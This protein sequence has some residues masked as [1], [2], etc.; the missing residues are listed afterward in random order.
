MNILCEK[1]MLAFFSLCLVKI[2]FCQDIP[3]INK[4]L[5]SKFSINSEFDYSKGYYLKNA[6]IVDSFIFNK[7][8]LDSV[9]SLVSSKNIE[10][11]SI[12]NSFIK[13]HHIYDLTRDVYVISYENKKELIIPKKEH[14]AYTGYEESYFTDS[15]IIYFKYSSK[16]IV[17]Y[18]IVK[19]NIIWEYFAD[20]K[21]YTE[22]VPF[23]NVLV[24]STK[25]EFCI[26]D[27]V[28]GSL[29]WQYSIGSLTE[30]GKSINSSIE[31]QGNYAYLWAEKN[32]VYCIDI[33]KHKVKWNSFKN[34][35]RARTTMTMVFDQDT[36]FFG[37]YPHIYAVNKYTG[38]IFWKSEEINIS[39][40]YIVALHPKWIFY[41]EHFNEL[42]AN[43]LCA[44]N[45]A[46]G[47]LAYK[48]FTSEDFPPGNAN[49]DD[50]EAPLN[51]LDFYAISWI[52]KTHGNLLIGTYLD[53][54]YCF[55]ILE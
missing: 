51:E 9:V 48:G 8:N 14:A 52:R 31:I 6:I 21:V 22:A 19:K 32:G 4:L 30:K 40:S 7:P 25:N 15:N 3:T 39:G 46:T 38:D 42:N 29:V 37:L 11:K 17:A 44:L 27:K 12:K 49:G 53:K 18:D 50:S 2:G 33:K 26:I 47:K 20:E 10:I 28:T 35:E 34:T 36:L 23:D 55:E 24:F 13:K 1:W 45:R 5:K 43:F 54:L 16:S 41:Y